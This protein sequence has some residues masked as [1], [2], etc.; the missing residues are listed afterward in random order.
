MTFFKK[1]R[2]KKEVEA[3]PMDLDSIMKKYDNGGFP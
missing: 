1:L 2:K 3:E